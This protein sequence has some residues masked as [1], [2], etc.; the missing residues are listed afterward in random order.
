M[1]KLPLVEGKAKQKAGEVVDKIVPPVRLC[2][3][4]VVYPVNY[5][6]YYWL[7][8]VERF[9]AV[10]KPA[11]GEFGNPV[12]RRHGRDPGVQRLRP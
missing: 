8:A 2:D 9:P 7:V 6:Y 4:I 12:G 11:G 1:R 10:R 3:N 5:P